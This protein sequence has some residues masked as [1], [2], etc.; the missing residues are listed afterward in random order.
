MQQCLA[1][2][3]WSVVMVGVVVPL[4]ILYHLEQRSRYSFDQEQWRRQQDQQ[5][6]QQRMQQP[7]VQPRVMAPSAAVPAASQPV[8][9]LAGVVAATSRTSINLH[10]L[11]LEPLLPLTGYWPLDVYLASSFVWSFAGLL[12][13]L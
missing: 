10:N 1:V 7:E 8:A 12:G 3:A 9:M 2:N 11:P 5:L 4:L 13:C 6:S